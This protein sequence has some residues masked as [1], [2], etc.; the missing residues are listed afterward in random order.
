MADDS[1][2]DLFTLLLSEIRDGAF[3]GGS[4]VLGF[5]WEDG[6]LMEMSPPR[7]DYEQLMSLRFIGQVMQHYTHDLNSEIGLM[8]M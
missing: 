2:D 8:F 1:G 6:T 5:E 7:E 3:G 4:I